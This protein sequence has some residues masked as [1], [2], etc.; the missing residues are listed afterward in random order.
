MVIFGLKTQVLVTRMKGQLVFHR[1]S[2]FVSRSFLEMSTLGSG[3][4]TLDTLLPSRFGRGSILLDPYEYLADLWALIDSNMKYVTVS[5]HDKDRRT[6]VLA[7]LLV[8]LH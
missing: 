1:T 7:M 3:E 6:S 5:H 2:G 4:A 8:P